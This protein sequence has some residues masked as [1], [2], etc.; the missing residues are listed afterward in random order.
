M[1]ASYPEEEENHEVMHELCQG[2]WQ[3]G[4]GSLMEYRAL[5]AQAQNP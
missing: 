1:G 4:L 3:K 2:I 5:L